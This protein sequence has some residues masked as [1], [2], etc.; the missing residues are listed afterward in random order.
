[1]RW[2]PG[3]GTKNGLNFKRNKRKKKMSV[4]EIRVIDTTGDTKLTWD[5]EK[6]AEVK[7]AQDAFDRLKAEGYISYRVKPG[8][9]EGAIMEKFDP[10]AGLVILRPRIV[11]G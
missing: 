11:G 6:K 8:G 5:T 1:M 10:D 4:G 2:F 3:D 9:G 7:A